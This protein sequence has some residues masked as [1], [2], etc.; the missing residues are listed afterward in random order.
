[1]RQ[2]FVPFVSIYLSAIIVTQ[3]I[4]LFEGRSTPHALVLLNLVIIDTVAALTLSTFVQ[5]RVVN[6]VA[7]V[8]VPPGVALSRLEQSVLDRLNRRFVGERLYAREGLTIVQLADLLGTQEHVLRRVINQGLGFRNFN[9]FL[10][11]HRLKEA[12]E[13]LGDPQ[14]RR[15]PVLT[16]ALEVGYGSV[17]PFNRAFKE[18]FGVTADRVSPPESPP[19]LTV[20]GNRHESLS[21]GKPP[22]A[23]VRACA[24]R[25]WLTE[26]LMRLILH[27]SRRSSSRC[28][29]PPSPGRR[30]TSGSTR[31]TVSLLPWRR[32]TAC[33]RSS[34]VEEQLGRL[35]AVLFV[36]GCRATASSWLRMP[37]TGLERHARAVC[38]T[39]SGML[40][41]RTEKSASAKQG[42]AVRASWTTRPSWRI[43]APLFAAA[44]ASGRRSAAHRDLRR[45]HGLELRAA[46]R[47]GPGRRRRGRV[48]RRCA[49]LVR[50]HAAV[51]AQCAGAG[52]YRSAGARGEVNARAAYFAR[53]LLK[54][55]T[56]AQIAASDPKLGEV[57]RAS[58]AR[59]TPVTTVDRSHSIS[60]RSD[61]TGPARGSACT[62]PFSC[63]TAST[64]G[65]SRATPHG[66]IANIVN[67]RQPGSATFKELPQ[68]NHHFTRY[69]NPRDA[70]RE[71]NGKETQSLQ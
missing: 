35:P 43:T 65:S 54:G 41:Q 36:N 71:Q 56:P 52:R 45:E 25:F 4:V 57:W 63:S 2:W 34:L 51:R 22:A 60:R 23:A 29:F 38:I 67:N 16:I 37:R 3:V 12:A 13:R 68:L 18:R 44:G 58:S 14:L 28:R 27:L 8:D 26:P 48:G 5:W 39:E 20:S 55:E 21:F 49:D 53:Y 70:Y 17:G 40:W 33:A 30:N 11:T 50:A 10:H 32:L 15:I 19:A 42:H 59:A 31:N 61:R 66:C 1:L 24:L 62:R 46:R 7:A 47:G 69:A 64:T 9:D 6:W